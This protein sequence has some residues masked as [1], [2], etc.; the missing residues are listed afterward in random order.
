[1]TKRDSQYL[2]KKST[3]DSFKKVKKEVKVR[4]ARRPK[5]E[6]MKSISN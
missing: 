2:R 3:V 1:M 4:F 5:K 6:E